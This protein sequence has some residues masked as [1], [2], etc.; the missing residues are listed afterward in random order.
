MTGILITARVGS[1]RLPQKHFIEANGKPF[2]KWLVLRLQNAF[3]KELDSKKVKIVIATSVKPENKEFE[4]R[5]GSIAEV[6][7]GDDDNIPHRHFQC[8]THLGFSNI[9]SIDGD[10]ILCSVRGAYEVYKNLNADSAIDIC[11]T[12]GLPLGM[13]VS[14]YSVAY[15]EKCLKG[16]ENNKM[17]TGWGRV[18]VNHREKKIKMGEHNIHSSL[19]FTLD[20]ED[21][22]TFFSAII[23]DLKERI[24]SIS[25]E[26]LIKFVEQK[27]YFK[28]NSHLS[29]QYWKNFNESKEL[30]QRNEKP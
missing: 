14:G 7:Y 24:V 27:K 19:R 15:L 9:I 11:S 10:D 16:K 18:F 4:K 2:I 30:E 1:S 28:I 26:D 5:T 25:D 20:Y 23:N 3:K 13:N 8:A 29:E 12:T 22:A 17:E 6:F 21:D